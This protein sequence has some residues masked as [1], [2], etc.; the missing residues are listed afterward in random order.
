M[1]NSTSSNRYRPRLLTRLPPAEET[2]AA[3]A[4][5]P[6]ARVAAVVQ[7]AAPIRTVETTSRRASS[8]TS[9]EPEDVQSFYAT[10][11]LSPYKSRSTR[12]AANSGGTDIYGLTTSQNAGARS[13]TTFLSGSNL[14][15]AQTFGDL[16]FFNY[17]DTTRARIQGLPTSAM[18]A[19][20]I[21]FFNNGVSA[22]SIGEST[23]YSNGRSAMS[24]GNST[25][26]SNGESAMS[27]GNTTFY[28]NGKSCTLVGNNRFCN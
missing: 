10:E 2:V 5:P 18:R 17:A 26:Y 6:E 22:M 7:P 19:G 25:F 4:K 14:Q 20:D 15:S 24:V 3:V 12:S 23:F 27:V 16:T 13:N 11:D 9:S 8:R 21:T 1:Q 28:S